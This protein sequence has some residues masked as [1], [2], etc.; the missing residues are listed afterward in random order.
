MGYCVE[1]ESVDWNGEEFRGLM[2][3][4][5]TKKNK[6]NSWLGIYVHGYVQGCCFCIARH[7][8]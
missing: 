1:N 6:K 5:Y 8:N 2:M 3:H 7:F 4:R